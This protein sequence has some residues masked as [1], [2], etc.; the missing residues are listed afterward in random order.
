MNWMA[1]CAECGSEFGARHRAHA[2]CSDR[3]AG[4]RW[5]RRGRRPAD[6]VIANCEHCGAEFLR[7]NPKRRYCSKPCRD[8]AGSLRRWKEDRRKNADAYRRRAREWNR[9][10]RE[11]VNARQREWARLNPE[12]ARIRL[13]RRRARERGAEGTWTVDEWNELVD[14]Y[15]GRCAYC[16]CSEPL[17]VDHRVPLARGGS[18]FISNILPAC[19]RCNKR[20]SFRVEEE[21][22]AECV[23]ERSAPVALVHDT[24]TGRMRLREAR[25]PLGG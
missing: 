7:R 15:D 11:R 13:Q 2:L 1:A 3:C 5:R 25:L 12:R 19:S 8:R 23:A 22:R 20:K 10:N 18:N 16:G 14:R 24:S 21:F 9:R 17:T 4:K 6:P